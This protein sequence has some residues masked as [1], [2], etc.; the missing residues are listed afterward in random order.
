M[1]WHRLAIV[2]LNA[3]IFTAFVC[4][5]LPRRAAVACRLHRSFWFRA[6]NVHHL[7]AFK[8][9][10]PNLP[11]TSVFG[12]KAFCDAALR[13]ILGEQN[14]RLFV[15]LKKPKGKEQ[16]QLDKRYSRLVSK[17]RQ[18]IESF[19]KWLNDKTQIQ[20]ASSVRSANGLLLHCF[21]KLS[22]ALLLLVFYS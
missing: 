10:S 9:Q 17:F 1:N 20:T 12:D 11:N 4:I 5:C 14:T 18:P 19:F 2:P 22:F 8:E 3:F 7:T 6:G 21:G 15:R 13:H 16:S